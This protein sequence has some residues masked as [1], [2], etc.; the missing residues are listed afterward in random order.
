ESSFET[1]GLANESTARLRLRRFVRAVHGA[2]RR[3]PFCRDVRFAEVAHA[4]WDDQGVPVGQS[5]LLDS[6]PGARAERNGRMEYRDGLA[7]ADLRQR[8]AS[9]HSTA[10]AALTG[11]TD[12][13]QRC[14]FDAR[15]EIFYTTV[16]KRGDFPPSSRQNHRKL[17]WHGS[18]NG[19]VTV[20]G[21]PDGPDSLA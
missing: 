2:W 20:P 14:C 10:R 3:P 4:A 16:R 15:P 11:G 13:P 5:P 21:C 17:G 8:L 18:C 6:A 12:S 19:H 7:L 9:E 1:R